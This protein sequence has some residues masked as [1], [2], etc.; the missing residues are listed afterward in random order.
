MHLELGAGASLRFWAP[1]QIIYLRP[2]QGGGPPR[3]TSTVLEGV[4]RSPRVYD[5][6]WI[7]Y[8]SLEAEGLLVS[9][10]VAEDHP[11]VTV[12]AALCQSIVRATKATR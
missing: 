7:S 2:L 6:L 11:L 1:G 9:P 3:R 8:E 5:A 4:R 10:E 12:H